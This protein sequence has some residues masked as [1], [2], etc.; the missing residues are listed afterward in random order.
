MSNTIEN[1][2]SAVDNVNVLIK[3]SVDN[4]V[5]Q[6]D[7]IEKIRQGIEYIAGGIQDNSATAEETASTSEELAAQ[8]SMLNEMVNKFEI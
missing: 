4:A 1:V 8:A 6:A 3:T 7:G 2:V 5:E